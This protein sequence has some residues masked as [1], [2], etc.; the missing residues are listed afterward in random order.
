MDGSCI[1]CSI[2]DKEI[3]AEIV[4]E[5]DEMLSFKDMKPQAPL[6][7]LV[8]PKKHISSVNEVSGED[9][10]ILGRIF[11]KIR[12]MA[13]DAAVSEGGYRIV[14]NCNRDAGQEVFHLHVHLLGG[15]R[16]T[17]PPG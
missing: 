11:L 10:A 17:W 2:R 7:L 13:Q 15:R 1:F 8:I 5:D 4:Y 16:F 12:D 3:P 9:A 6:H 14:V